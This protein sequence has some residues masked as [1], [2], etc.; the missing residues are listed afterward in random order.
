QEIRNVK[1]GAVTVQWKPLT[2][3]P[4][5]HLLDTCV[6]NA[7]VADSVGVKYLPE[8]NL[9]TDEGDEDTDDEDFNADSRGWFS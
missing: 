2:S 9:D 8:Y 4:T 6:Y 3:H 1:T 5:N 7:M